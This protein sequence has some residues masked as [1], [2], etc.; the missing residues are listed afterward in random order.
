MLVHCGGYW[1]VSTTQ[2]HW[3]MIPGQCSYVSYGEIHSKVVGVFD[4]VPRCEAI[5]TKFN[6]V[7]VTSS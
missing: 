7:H 3:Y 2:G 6:R 4:L 1:V 5:L